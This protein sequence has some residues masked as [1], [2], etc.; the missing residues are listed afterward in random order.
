MPQAGIAFILPDTG[1]IYRAFQDISIQNRASVGYDTLL[2]RS[3]QNNMVLIMAV[4][5]ILSAPVAMLS[6]VSLKMRRL[7]LFSPSIRSPL[8]AKMAT[9]EGCVT[10]KQVQASSRLDFYRGHTSL[11][12]VTSNKISVM[13]TKNTISVLTIRLRCD[14][15]LWQ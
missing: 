4:I 2:F 11:G 6:G 8:V 3:D 9:E 15:I 14:I 13:L 12:H 5:S 10:T 7:C 1:V